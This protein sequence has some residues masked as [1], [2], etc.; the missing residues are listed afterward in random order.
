[1]RQPVTIKD[2]ALR[3]GCGVATVSR[4]LNNTGSASANMRG[5]VLAATDALGFEFSEVG[6]S[7]QSN[8]TRTIGCVVPPWQTLSLQTRY[9]VRRRFFNQQVIKPCLCAQIMI[10]NL[11][12]KLFEC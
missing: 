1:M 11:K 2:V 4:V 12:H 3:A 5:R 9:R 6:R 7:L 10:V 8:T